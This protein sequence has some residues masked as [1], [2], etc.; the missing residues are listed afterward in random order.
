M[1]TG[2]FKRSAIASMMRTLAW[3]GMTQAMS[4]IV[5]PACSSAF[6]DGVEHRDDGLFVNF[7][8]RHVDRLQVIVDVF[9]RDRVARTA[10]GHEKDV[11]KISV[12]RRYEC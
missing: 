12:A 9:A 8:A 11:G 2:I 7:L 5:R 3:W 4:S 10:A 1:S 6:F